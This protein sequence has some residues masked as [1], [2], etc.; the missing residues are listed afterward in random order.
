MKKYLKIAFCALL[1][2]SLLYAVFGM[3][4]GKNRLQA[5]FTEVKNSDILEKIEGQLLDKLRE[6]REKSREN[7]D[8]DVNDV[9]DG[10]L[11]DEDGVIIE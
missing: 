8:V 4:P 1:V 11:I 2:A 3:H 9:T 6:G 10:M 7:S 5:Q